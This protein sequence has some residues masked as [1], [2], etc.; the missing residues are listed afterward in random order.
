MKGIAEGRRISLYTCIHNKLTAA[1][2]S[3]FS[4]VVWRLY[5]MLSQCNV[6]FSARQLQSLGESTCTV[7]S[8]LYVRWT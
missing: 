6:H 7:L 4:L 5:S 2:S 1:D 3:T 8:V